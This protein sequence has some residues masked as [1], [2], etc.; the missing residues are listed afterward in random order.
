MKANDLQMPNALVFSYRCGYSGQC[1]FR[2]NAGWCSLSPL[3]KTVLFGRWWG[4][5][6][7]AG[8]PRWA[9]QL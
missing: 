9:G 5:L 2:N 1:L 4:L 3:R 6:A 8:F 7:L